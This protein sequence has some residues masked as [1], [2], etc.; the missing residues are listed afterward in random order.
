[1]IINLNQPCNV[2]LTA[3]GAEVYNKYFR[4]LHDTCK[5]I[6]LTNLKAGV[7]LS[8]QLWELMSIFGKHLYNGAENCFANNDISF[9][10]KVVKIPERS[11]EE[12]KELLANW[13]GTLVV[14]DHISPSPWISVEDELPS[15][16]SEDHPYSERVFVRYIERLDDQE[17]VRHCF[18]ELLCIGK[19]RKWSRHQNDNERVT[20]WMPI[21]ELPKE[22]KK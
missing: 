21:P 10:D 12:I 6:E 17:H 11:R 22:E 18:D 20:H 16:K 1:M 15:R 9:N 7:E 4:K 8:L 14:G 2:I 5:L 19:I 3:H 13:K